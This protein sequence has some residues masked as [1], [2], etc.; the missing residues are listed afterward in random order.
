MLIHDDSRGE[1]LIVQAYRYKKPCQKKDFSNDDY[2][3]TDSDQI[4]IALDFNLRSILIPFNDNGKI[5]EEATNADDV[6]SDDEKEEGEIDIEANN[7]IIKPRKVSQIIRTH[8]YYNYLDEYNERDYSALVIQMDEAIYFYDIKKRSMKD[9]VG[10]GGVVKLEMLRGLKDYIYFIRK[11]ESG[12]GSDTIQLLKTSVDRH[13][14]KTKIEIA[15]APYSGEI[16]A[17]ELDPLNTNDVESF[18][19]ENENMEEW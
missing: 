3:D 19:Q 17:F 13:G 10:D 16:L 12:T 4:E 8:K 11:D 2:W 9:I 6:E 1:R 15:T 5:D 18:Y 14:L 7:K